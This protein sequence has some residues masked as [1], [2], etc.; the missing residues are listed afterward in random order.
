[1]SQIILTSAYYDGIQIYMEMNK[2]NNFYMT[3]I[4]FIKILHMWKHW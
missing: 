4:I 2:N 1:M 3:G